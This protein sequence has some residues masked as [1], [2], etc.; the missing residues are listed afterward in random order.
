MEGG[1]RAW[2]AAIGRPPALAVVA[3]PASAARILVVDDDAQI[4]DLLE[5]FLTQVGYDV[6]CAGSGAQALQ[7]MLAFEPHA[8]L[9][10]LH[11]PGMSGLEVLT[12]LNEQRPGLPVILITGDDQ[13]ARRTMR[14]SMV[15]LLIKPFSL[16]EV[17]QAV[18]AALRARIA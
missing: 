7:I 15:G 8:V 10:D 3:S 14:K 9:L 4:T 17:S 6:R 16:G 13:L 1:G 18:A 11:M 5:L 2:R 12:R